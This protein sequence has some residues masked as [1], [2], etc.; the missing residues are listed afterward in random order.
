MLSIAVDKV[1][2]QALETPAISVAATITVEPSTQVPFPIRIPAGAALPRD[3]F[4]RVQGLPVTAAL[5][6]GHSTAP[7]AW[8]VPLSAVSRLKIALPVTVTGR[9]DVEITLVAADGTPL[10]SARTT[11]IV[12]ATQGRSAPP[13]AASIL[14]AQTPS[15]R[16]AQ[17]H[18][19]ERPAPAAPPRPPAMTAEAREQA[20]RLLRRGNAQIADG[21]V[22]PARLLFE[23]AAELGLAEAAIA[24][25]R[26]YDPAELERLNVL[27]IQPDSKEAR[28]WYERARELG[29]DTDQRLRTL[30]AN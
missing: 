16:P 15:L 8:A 25:A 19:G 14:R 20:M 6:E 17:P 9:S 26:L 23:R 3:G 11:V 24:L 28:R 2:P 13:A 27:G 29:A 18:A 12:T 30:G 7:G 21:N 22:A 5:S 10:S 1:H 4:L